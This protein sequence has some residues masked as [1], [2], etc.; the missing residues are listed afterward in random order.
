MT[1]LVGFG[2]VLLLLPAIVYCRTE[3][4][5]VVGRLECASDPQKAARVQV[6]LMDY[7]GYIKA[8]YDQLPCHIEI[9]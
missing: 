2:I 7:D 1:K 3:C 6:F 4:A 9:I 8:T 5:I